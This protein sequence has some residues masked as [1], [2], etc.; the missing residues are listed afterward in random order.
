MVPFDWPNAIS[1]LC[2]ISIQRV[3]CMHRFRD[4]CRRSAIAAILHICPYH[5]GLPR[6]NWG[7]EHNTIRVGFGVQVSKTPVYHVICRFPLFVALF[8]SSVLTLLVGRQEGHQACKKLSGGMLAWLSVWGEVILHMAQQTLL[9][10]TISCSSKSRSVVSFWYRLARVVPDKGPLNGCCC[11]SGIWEAV[12]DGCSR[13]T[14]T[15]STL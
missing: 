2:P 10:L 8:V 4:S 13:H 9:P 6:W 1:Y 11:F 3:A 14:R 15:S 12:P 5:T 7:S